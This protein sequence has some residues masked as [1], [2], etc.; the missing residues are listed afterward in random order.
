MNEASLDAA[1]APCKL[2]LEPYESSGT[3]L[4]GDNNV[5]ATSSGAIDDFQDSIVVVSHDDATLETKAFDDVGHRH[6]RFVLAHRS[7]PRWISLGLE[8]T[9]NGMSTALIN[10]YLVTRDCGGR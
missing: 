8:G 4:S 7:I 9:S 2:R 10:K 6:T 1:I 3:G 5:L